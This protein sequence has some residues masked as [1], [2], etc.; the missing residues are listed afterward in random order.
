[1]IAQLF[2]ALLVFIIF[3]C[4]ISSII[5]S[6]PYSTYSGKQNKKLLENMKKLKK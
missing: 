3:I 4:V 2:A 5:R 6:I 1:M